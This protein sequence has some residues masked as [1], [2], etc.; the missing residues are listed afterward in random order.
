M[1]VDVQDVHACMAVRWECTASCPQRLMAPVCIARAAAHVARRRARSEEG[2]G[3]RRRSRLILPLELGALS[4]RSHDFS[5]APRSG[6][7]RPQSARSAPAGPLR[8]LLH[9][10][11]PNSMGRTDGEP[12]AQTGTASPERLCGAWPERR[13]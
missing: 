11:L 5:G 4:I 10:Y 6:W 7:L 8:S 2:R 13:T 12:A 1:D 9:F 3:H